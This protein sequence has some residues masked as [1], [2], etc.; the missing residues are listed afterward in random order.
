MFA[1]VADRG[2]DLDLIEVA[3]GQDDEPA[4]DA[5]E[6]AVLAGL[7]VEDDRAAGRYRFAHALVRETIYEDISRARR[8]RL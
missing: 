2:F 6:A 1:A 8:A 5:A 4:L 7:L 3:T